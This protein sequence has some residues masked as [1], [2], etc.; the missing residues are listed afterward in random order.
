ME[1][2]RLGHRKTDRGAM[3]ALALAT[4]L[5]SL[6][7]SMA[8][9]A[10]PV[11]SDQ[12]SA[13]FAS[14]QW[15][16]VAYLLA[17]TTLVVGAGRLGDLMGRARLLQSGIALFTV[18]S[19]L[20][21]LAPSLPVLIAAR[22]LQGAGGAAMMAMAM[23]LVQSVVA[24]ERTGRAMG[25]MGTMSALGTA[26]GPSVGGFILGVAGW[27]A[28]FGLVLPLGLITLA[29]VRRSLRATDR[30]GTDAD[31]T[32]DGGGLALLALGLAAYALAMT[33]GGRFGSGGVPLL[34]GTA[35]CA[36]VL[37]GW[38]EKRTLVPL[39]P[40][41]AVRQPLLAVRLSTNVLVGSVMMATLVVGP[42]YLA[43]VLGLDPAGVGLVLASGPVFSMLSGVPAGRMVDRFGAVAGIRIGLIAIA[44]GVFALS[45]LPGLMGLLG[46]IAAVAVLTP[47]YQ[48]F[49]AA[50]NTAVMADVAPDRRGVVS[51]LLNL[52]RNLGLITGASLIGTI[53]AMA[54]G[55]ATVADA[56]ADAI[57]YGQALT[58]RICGLIA[59]AA[60]GLSLAPA[61]RA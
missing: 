52:S 37:F 3:L 45:A 56:P 33:V 11:F 6:G 34:L 4:L 35:I 43:R 32:F 40:S 60:L 25:L 57:A 13:P 46:Y 29:V 49:L 61:R 16:V 41:D 18:A 2:E 59:L 12:F 17:S 22:V 58:F 15:V 21:A 14:V 38:H 28:L 19:A 39:I 27:R 47:G 51:G 26:L 50:N 9:V 55:T 54:T 23:A 31:T 20:C 53:F 8:N 36:V 42:F 44:V 5:S 24:R 10:L 48:L 7:V 30:P 1:D